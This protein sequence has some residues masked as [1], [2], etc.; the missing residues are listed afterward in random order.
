MVPLDV[1]CVGLPLSDAPIIGN[2]FISHIFAISVLVISQPI[3]FTPVHT[4]MILF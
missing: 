2:W 3:N 4:L 1:G